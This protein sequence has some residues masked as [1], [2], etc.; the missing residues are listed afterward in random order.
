MK[1]PTTPRDRRKGWKTWN[2]REKGFA[3]ISVLTILSLL[4]VIAV[5]LLTLSTVEARRSNVA[6]AQEEAQANARF[7]LQMA[8]AELQATL[9]TDRAITAS[10]GSGRLTSNELA[11]GANGGKRFLRNY[12]GVWEAAKDPRNAA[13][14]FIYDQTDPPQ[15][16]DD[17]I[18]S[19]GSIFKG[20]LVSD[21]NPEKMR[22]QTFFANASSPESLGFTRIQYND[23]DDNEDAPVELVGA[24]TV[25]PGGEKVFAGA[26]PI[27]RLDINGNE[28]PAGRYAWWVGDNNQKAFVR[29]RDLKARNTG[30]LSAAEHSVRAGT[31]GAFGATAL[32]DTTEPLDLAYN[33]L[34]TDQLLTYDQLGVVDSVGG[35]SVPREN[36]QRNFHDVTT[37]ADSLLVNVA[38]GGERKDLSLFFEGEPTNGSWESTIIGGDPPRGPYNQTAL[39]DHTEFETGNW[40]SFYTH[41]HAHK[42]RSNVVLRRSDSNGTTLLAPNFLDD[43]NESNYPF[44]NSQRK[45]I[46]PVI[47]RCAMVLSVGAESLNDSNTEGRIRQNAEMVSPNNGNTPVRDPMDPNRFIENEYN[48]SF[49][50]LPIIT[51]WNPYNVPLR[52]DGFRVFT[53]GA[54]VSHSIDVSGGRS[55][56]YEWNETRGDTIGSDSNSPTRGLHVGRNFTMEPGEYY[57]FFGTK[58]QNNQRFDQWALGEWVSSPGAIDVDFE[59]G[60]FAGG[61]VRNSMHR[62]AAYGENGQTEDQRIFGFWANGDDTVTIRTRPFFPKGQRSSDS[63]P[64]PGYQGLLYY[65]DYHSF[66]AGL[67][68]FPLP[69]R[70]TGREIPNTNVRENESAKLGGKLVWRNDEDSPVTADLRN[71]IQEQFIPMSRLTSGRKVPFMM[72]DVRVKGTEFNSGDRNFNP[73]LTWLHNI[74]QHGFFGITSAGT[75]ESLGTG[76]NSRS[77]VATASHAQ[78]TTCKFNQV[79]N[80][81]DALSTHEFELIDRRLT[82]YAGASYNSRTGKTRVV[83]TEIPLAPMQSIAQFQHVPQEAIDSTRWS[84]ISLQNYAIGNSYA[85]PLIEAGEIAYP[86]PED[87]SPNVLSGDSDSR[88]WRIWLDLAVDNADRRRNSRPDLQGVKWFE[89]VNGGGDFTE[90]FKP[91]RHVDRSWVANTLMFDDFF[92]SG[93]ADYSGRYLDRAG[94]EGLEVQ[95]MIEQFVEGESVLPNHRYRF[96]DNGLEKDEIQT[97][98]EDDTEGYLHTARHIVLEGGFNVNSLS[99]RAWRTFLA[100]NLQKRYPV[101]TRDGKVASDSDY[102]EITKDRYIIGRTNIGVDDANDGSESWMQANEIDGDELDDL[103][104]AIVDEVAKRGPFRSVAEFV[105]RRVSGNNEEFAVKGALQAA[106]DRTVN[107]GEPELDSSSISSADYEFQLAATQAATAGTPEYVMQADLLQSI[108]S[109]LVARGDSFIIRAYGESADGSAQAW[110]EAT[111]VRTYDYVDSSADQEPG[112]RTQNLTSEQNQRFGRRFRQVSFRF[113]APT[114]I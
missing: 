18:Y 98:L 20:Y 39:S 4:A 41:Y 60:P 26:V 10:A 102:P 71:K 73:N 2:R 55:L 93:L 72:I 74:P 8:I 56:D 63:D 62:D 3:L 96:T 47:V 15:Y 53:Q 111:V 21:A 13:G 104:E 97:Q 16:A 69:N 12:V 86:Y 59:D 42:D 87:D 85:S 68:T 35:Q 6:T 61:F 37:F 52:V 103:A 79:T 77:Q 58:D 80:L 107:A 25:G 27:T 40:L 75:E 67:M 78:A 7:A 38:S 29:A 88:T 30:D 28:R 66:Q 14:R 23:D 92:F 114:S 49:H 19:D 106:L 17:G 1:T 54:A 36:I 44:W 82:S 31:P 11:E 89:T 45:L 34:Q 76:A 109:L 24:N 51:L 81:N 110:C 101:V 94:G 32:A 90:H 43:Y 48:L 65:A 33:T 112:I 99:V 84:G 64:A 50:A 5:G 46:S 113:L 9:G 83:A 91:I 70:P 57:T 100:S 95:D 108:G 22:D 105:N